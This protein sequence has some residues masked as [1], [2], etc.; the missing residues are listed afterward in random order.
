MCKMVGTVLDSRQTQSLPSWNLHVMKTTSNQISRLEHL[1]WKSSSK[2]FN[3]GISGNNAGKK[4]SSVATL[5]SL[6]QL[7]I[8]YFFKNIY[9][10][11]HYFPNFCQN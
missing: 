8:F 1:S 7:K 11:L 5:S 6:H 4:L 3:V 9:V 2:L 10:H